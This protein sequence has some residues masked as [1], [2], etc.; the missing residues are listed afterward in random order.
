LRNGA[1]RAA[2]GLRRALL[3]QLSLTAARA[4][5]SRRLLAV[6]DVIATMA[7]HDLVGLVGTPPVADRDQ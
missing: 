3:C 2:D 4:A 6:L 5:R 7:V 1:A